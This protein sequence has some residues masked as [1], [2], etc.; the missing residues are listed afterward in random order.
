MQKRKIILDLELRIFR[1]PCVWSEEGKGCLELNEDEYGE[2]AA[3]LEST[4][5]MFLSHT[6]RHGRATRKASRVRRT[7][8]VIHNCF[9]RVK[10]AETHLSNFGALPLNGR[11]FTSLTLAHY[12]SI[13]RERVNKKKYLRSAALTVTARPARPCAV[14]HAHTVGTLHHF[15]ALPV[16]ILNKESAVS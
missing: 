10:W 14:L 9:S 15:N 1:L 8:L 13:S 12:H 16:R 11:K 7:L 3:R 6:L 5:F 2:A 4:D